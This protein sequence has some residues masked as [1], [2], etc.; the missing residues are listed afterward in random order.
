MAK[1]KKNY[2]MLKVSMFLNGWRAVSI[3]TEVPRKSCITFA[4]NFFCV[5]LCDCD[6]KQ[7]ADEATDQQDNRINDLII[8]VTAWLEVSTCWSSYINHCI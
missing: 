8:E 2:D 1:I 7:Q 5:S 3:Q 4:C 6:F